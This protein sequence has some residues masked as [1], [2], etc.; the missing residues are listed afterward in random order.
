MKADRKTAFAARSALAAPH[1]PRWSASAPKFVVT[2]APLR[3][4]FAGGGSDLPEFY[5]SDFGAVLSTTIDKFIYVTVKRHGA[6]FTENYRLNYFSSEHVQRLDEIE[7]AIIRECLRLVPLDPPLYISTVGDLPASSGLGSSSSFA[8]G[9]ISA[10]HAMRGE[11]APPVRIYEEAAEVEIEI[12]K[13]PIGK[14][15]HAAAAFG[16]LNYIRFRS[17]DSIALE[18]LNLGPHEID[19][20]FKNLQFFW[21]GITRD[22]GQILAEQQSNT[23]GKLVPDLQVIRD[24]AHELRNLMRDTLDMEAFGGVLDRGWQL[25]RGLATNISNPQIDAWY[26]AARAAGAWGGKLMGAGGGGF[27]LFVTPPELHSKVRAALRGLEEVPI[28]F[29]PTGVRLLLPPASE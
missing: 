24:Q 8:V 13:R 23:A 9:L 19:H 29:E 18:P 4:S 11:R 15:D 16:G 5:R 26:D 14:Q 1:I 12:L 7:N 17:D 3:I 21:T 27:L 2:A 20:V 28:A 6:L 25:K 10:L 22:A